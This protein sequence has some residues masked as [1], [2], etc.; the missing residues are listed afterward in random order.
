MFVFHLLS[1]GNITP[2][3]NIAPVGNSYF[4]YEISLYKFSREAEILVRA[5]TIK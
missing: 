1:F 2:N 5:Y 4:R 3:Y